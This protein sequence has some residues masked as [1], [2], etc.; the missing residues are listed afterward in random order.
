MHACKY[1][2]ICYV[3]TLIYVVLPPQIYLSGIPVFLEVG[4]NL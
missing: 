1:V 3:N 2:L 4:K